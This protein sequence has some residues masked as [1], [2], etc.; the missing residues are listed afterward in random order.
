[1]GRAITR[2]CAH[3]HPSLYTPPNT[4][5]P[6]YQPTNQPTTLPTSLPVYQVTNLF[7]YLPTFSAS[8]FPSAKRLRRISSFIPST[9]SCSSRASLHSIGRPYLSRESGFGAS[10]RQ[11]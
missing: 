4:H 10:L 7:T 1:M 3:T 9:A 8:R 6:T 11:G 2:T 5:I